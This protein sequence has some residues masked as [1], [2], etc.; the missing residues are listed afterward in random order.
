MDRKGDRTVEKPQLLK[1]CNRMR[2]QL[3]QWSSPAQRLVS[4]QLLCKIHTFYNN[5]LLLLFGHLLGAFM[6]IAMAG[7]FGSADYYGLCF[8]RETFERVP[9]DKPSH[10]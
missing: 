3:I 2:S 8:L 4:R 9:W 6:G 10:G 5:I 7:N 1:D